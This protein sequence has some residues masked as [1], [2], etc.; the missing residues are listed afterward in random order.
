[1]KFNGSKQATCRVSPDQGYLNSMSPP[2]EMGIKIW[3]PAGIYWAHQEC[4]AEN[5]GVQNQAKN[6]DGATALQCQEAVY[7]K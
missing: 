3:V 7:L 6:V 2:W 1:M 5:W 4:L